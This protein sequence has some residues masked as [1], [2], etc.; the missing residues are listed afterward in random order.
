MNAR[1]DLDAEIRERRGEVQV[2]EKK[3]LCKK[4][5]T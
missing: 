4:K 5:K 1:K 2:Q 3:E